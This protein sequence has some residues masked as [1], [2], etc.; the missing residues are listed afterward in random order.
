[1]FRIQDLGF[2]GLEVRI[3]DLGLRV[4]SGLFYWLGFAGSGLRY[5]ALGCKYLLVVSREW[6]RGN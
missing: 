5:L 4:A 1:M 6:R 2:R 3:Y